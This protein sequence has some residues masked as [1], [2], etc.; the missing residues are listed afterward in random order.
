M[1]AFLL[2]V[3]AIIHNELILQSAPVFEDWSTG[4][5]EQGTEPQLCVMQVSE[6]LR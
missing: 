2:D 6:R 1:I 3:L 4:K 5:P